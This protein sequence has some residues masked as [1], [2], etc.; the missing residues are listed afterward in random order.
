[1]RELL[2]KFSKTNYFGTWFFLKIDWIAQFWWGF[3]LL[4]FDLWRYVTWSSTFRRYYS[5]TSLENRLIVL[6]HRIEKAFALP[7]TRNGF[8]RDTLFELSKLIGIYRKKRYSTKAL[9]YR[10]SIR[11]LRYYL[12]QH[13]KVAF[14]LGTLGDYLESILSPETPSVATKIINVDDFK[15][16]H[17]FA[18]L[19]RKR[20][21]I[22]RYTSEP[23]EREVIERAVNL[24]RHT[25]S[26]CNRQ[27]WRVHA[28]SDNIIKN[29]LLDLQGGNK[30]F[31]YDAQWLLI[32]TM[33]LAVFNS[34]R[35]RHEAY[36]DGGLFSMSLIYALQDQGLGTCAL[37]WCVIAK[38]ERKVRKLTGIGASEVVIMFLSVGKISNKVVV[39]NSEKR[40]VDEILFFHN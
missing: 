10:M 8:G 21:S 26:V 40:A 20:S 27:A 34:V 14:P 39:A 23:V 1:M 28:Y 24:A 32:I 6:A 13:Q 22:R 36:V 29:P 9:G 33:D 19:A 37:N 11:V 5:Q 16:L 12:D 30:G 7:D 35:E 31:G 17:G 15:E 3:E 2:I 4:I 38:K 18:K 25:P